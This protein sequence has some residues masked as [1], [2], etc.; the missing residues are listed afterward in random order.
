MIQFF[1]TRDHVDTANQFADSWAP[2]LRTHIRTEA[3]ENISFRKP[4]PGGVCIFMDFER[5]LPL[6]M[7]L[8]RRLTAAV[9]ALPEKYIVLNNPDHYIGRLRLLEV[10][11]EQGINDFRAF[12]ANMTPDDLRF[13]VFVRSEIDHNGPATPLLHSR[14]ELKRVLASD[15]FQD[16]QLQKHLMVTEFCDCMEAGGTFR[17]YSVMNINGTLIP[18][19]LFSSRD[20]VLKLQSAEFVD[21][22]SVAKEEDFLRNFPHATQILEIFRLAGVDYGRI[23]YG[24][25]NGRIQVWEINTNPTI[26]P[27]QEKIHPLRMADQAESARRIAAVLKTLSMSRAGT[28]AF[29]FRSA[30]M[31]PAKILQHFSRRTHRQHR[32]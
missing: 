14:D 7:S 26:V 24:V 21:T 8:A 9:R 17:K 31:L 12:R 2:E 29:P 22:D 6:E 1:G 27:V 16:P 13:P 3:Y 32:K 4:L 5:L 10:L 25:R 23:D 18:R 15:A 19:H 11:H 28:S 30:K 20:W